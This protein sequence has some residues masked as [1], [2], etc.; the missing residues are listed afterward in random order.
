MT[1]LLLA[2]KSDLMLDDWPDEAIVASSAAIVRTL[3]TCAVAW[4]EGDLEWLRRFAWFTERTVVP[5]H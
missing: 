5:L 3:E 4:Q 2:H 1:R